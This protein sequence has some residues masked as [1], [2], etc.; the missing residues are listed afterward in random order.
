MQ[1]KWKTIFSV[2][3]K[4]GVFRITYDNE[5]DTGEDG[6]K[7][8]GA[9]F[10]LMQKYPELI[11]EMAIASQFAANELARPFNDILNE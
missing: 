4:D 11:E 7:V 9:L 6:H 1:S 3:E 8:A 10:V 5:L 2:K